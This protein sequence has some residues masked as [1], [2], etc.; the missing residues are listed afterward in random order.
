VTRRDFDYPGRTAVMIHP[1][2]KLTV[3]WESIDPEAQRQIVRVLAMPELE[4]LA[5]M[6]DVH[7]GYD[8]C[9]GGVAL[10]RGVISP[11]FVGYDI[12]CGMCHVNTGATLRE[13]GLDS[14]DSRRKLFGRI[15]EIIPAGLGKIAGVGYDG[16][17][18]FKSALGDAAFDKKVNYFVRTQFCTLGSG[19]HFLEIGVNARGDVGVTIHSGSRRA[20]YEIASRYMKKG[21]PLPLDGDLGRAYVADMNW[22]LDFALANRRAMMTRVLEA[23]KLKYRTRRLISPEVM[24]NENHNHA[25]PSGE[26]MVLHRKGATPAEKGQ[27]GIIPAN[28]RDGVWITR[29]LGNEEFLSSASHGAGRKLSRAEAREA[30]SVRDMEKSMNGVVCR[31]DKDILDEAPWAYKPIGG[32]LAAQDGILVEVTDHFKPVIVLK[33]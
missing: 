2:L 1:K 17:F 3:P 28:Q 31:T 23:M 10:L 6:P 27:P 26:G 18:S 25:M 16:G 30:G 11:P 29:G 4:R 5:I 21:R 9:I 7:A 20:G 8:L 15:R 24:I 12:G 22:A 33:G 14:M 13:L 32:V 19:N